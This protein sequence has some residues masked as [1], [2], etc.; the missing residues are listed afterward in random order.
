M[1]AGA[2]VLE[3]NTFQSTRLRLEEW[4]LAERTHELNVH[5]ARL[6]REV[7]DEY[8]A[9]DG[10]PRFVAG[11]MGPTGKLPSSDDPML[12]D[13]S[14]QELSDTFREQAAAL[15]EGGADVLLVETSVDILEVKAALDG[16]RRAREEL[17]R[18]DVAVQAQVF[19]MPET[20]AMLLGTQ[21]PAVIATL[22]AM[23]VD[24]LGLNCSTGPEHMRDAIRVLTSH[25]RLPISCI[26][27]AGLPVEVEGETVYPML[28]GPFS[29]I[30]GEYVGQY[31]V[32]VVGGCCGT[33]PEHIQTLRET[34]GFDRA[35]APRT[36]EHVP[37]VS[38][39]VRAVALQ[40]DGTPLMIGERVNTL[41]SRKVK[42]LLLDDDY[43]G[44][45][46]S[47]P[48]AGRERRARA[49]RGRGDDRAAR[50]A[51]ADDRRSPSS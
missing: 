34:I 5:A 26:P 9:R 51:R 32:A 47:R 41:G 39:G 24:V 11:S 3:T 37:A 33:R 14:F 28:P 10:R 20:G 2:D 36:I 42:R 6:A 30:L 19:I 35:P 22:E 12:S 7:A 29:T 27:N 40:Q 31:G 4:G 1:D 25:S 46:G 45:V 23:Q 50:R 38:S 48:R 13:T 15:I 43:D 17:D 44:V 18:W 16:I 49:R 21:I 8:A